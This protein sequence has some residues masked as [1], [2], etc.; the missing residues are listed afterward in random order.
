MAIEVEPDEA[1]ITVEPGRMRPSRQAFS[2]IKR[3]MRSLVDP[4]GFRNSSLHQILGAP[5][6]S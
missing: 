1:S 4:D 2:R 6:A 3:A 5:G